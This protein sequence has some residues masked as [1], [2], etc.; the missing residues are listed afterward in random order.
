[1]K[2]VLK[3]KFFARPA[4]L[5]AEDLLGKFLVRKINGIEK[6]FSMITETES[7]DGIDDLASHAS[8]G[9]TA[10]TEVMFGPAG[11]IYVYLIYGMY[12]MLNIV[13][14]EENHPSAVLIRSTNNYS[15]PGRLTKGLSINKELNAVVASPS[16]GL[17]FED[18][19]V[20]V[21]K[22]EIEY[23][24]RIGVEYAGNIWSKKLWRFVYNPNKK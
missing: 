2:K 15:G 12:F 1:M 6:T 7:Y 17:W 24:P 18:R 13:T 21:N 4:P 10:R 20:K 22:K 3:E 8:K 19:G 9:K 5:V 23:T 11:R 14:G 16:T